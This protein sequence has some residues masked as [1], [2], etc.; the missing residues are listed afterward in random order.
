[1]SGAWKNE[2]RTG[3]TYTGHGWG[4]YGVK[5]TTNGWYAFQQPFTGDPIG[6]G[7]YGSRSDAQRAVENLVGDLIARKARRGNP[8][9]RRKTTVAR[10]RAERDRLEK[11][12]NATPTNVD[13]SK[14]I[15]RLGNLN[16]AIADAERGRNPSKGPAD[17][18]AARELALYAENIGPGTG[19]YV[20]N[21][22]V[23]IIA[24][25][26]RKLKKGVYNHTLAAKLWR[27]WMDTAAK[28]YTKEFGGSGTYGIFTP[29]TRD[30]AAKI[31]ADDLREE[32]ESSSNPMRKSKRRSAAQLAATR[33]LV[34]L[35][36]ARRKKGVKN[37]PEK[38][39]RAVNPRR[40]SAPRIYVVFKAKGHDVRFLTMRGPQVG[41]TLTRGD[42]VQWQDKKRAF[43]VAQY[44]ARKGG[45]EWQYGVTRRDANVATIAGAVAGKV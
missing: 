7:M 36:A 18:V 2:G 29:A 27:Y 11:K 35:N 4:V 17:T 45:S 30:A 28:E 24:N 41:W 22:R 31:V 25:L 14:I 20:Y 40:T 8:V 38:R 34:A 44:L 33:K 42:T 21:Q 12:L 13:A 23:S 15:R 43:R 3:W 1:M 6:I 5:R 16:V 39:R 26:R 37:R 32:V 19:G 10:L 9:K